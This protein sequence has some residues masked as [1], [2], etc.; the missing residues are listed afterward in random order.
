M[1]PGAEPAGRSR[2]REDFARRPLCRQRPSRR[3]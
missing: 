2:R 3:S 1:T